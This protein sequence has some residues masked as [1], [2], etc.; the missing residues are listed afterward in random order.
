MAIM[1]HLV[2][3]SDAKAIQ[4]KDLTDR[5][6]RK[7]FMVLTMICASV[8]IFIVVFLMIRG[9]IPFLKKYI[10][11]GQELRVSIIRFFFSST[12]FRSPNIYGVG[13]IIINTL[14]IVTLAIGVA[15][16]V[17]VLTAL[18][19]SKMA[20]KKLGKIFASVV[21]LLASIPS[22]IYGIFGMGIITVL[23]KNISQFFGYQSA[24]GLS[25]L[26]TVLV[27]AMM[28]MPTVTILSVTSINA[29][30]QNIINGSLALG[31]SPTQ[32]NFKV[33]L[34][35]A[36][37]GIFSAI[38]LGVGRALGEATAVSMVAGNRGSGPTFNLFDTTRTLTSTML[39]GLK[40]TAGLDYDIRFSVGIVLIVIIL[41]T[42]IG[43]NYIKRRLG[44]LR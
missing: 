24:G 1:E 37:S 40:E 14:Y 22:I 3:H 11:N 21:E 44:D 41:I 10:I 34:A 16:P 25:T 23:I 18:F 31:A 19:I 43:L 33:V 36:K 6:I 29:V 26:A 8:I 9:F 13:F 4:K 2:K 5:V 12:W 38:I 17:S 7:I 39:L 30:K 27:L 15:I 20:P 35:S 32:T 28:I 42:N